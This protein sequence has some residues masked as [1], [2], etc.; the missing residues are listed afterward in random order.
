MIKKVFRKISI[1]ILAL[2]LSLAMN[3]G[4]ICINAAAQADN[5]HKSARYIEPEEWNPTEITAY[6]FGSFNSYENYLMSGGMKYYNQRFASKDRMVRIQVEDPG[7]FVFLGENMADSSVITLYDQTKK[8]ALA[9][10]TQDDDIEYGTRVK[11]KDV[12]YVKMPAKVKEIGLS[13]A[14]IKE[15]FGGMRAGNTYYQAGT[16]K[17]TYHPFSITKRSAVEITISSLE[18]KGGAS[19]AY[20]EKYTKGRW[21]RIGST[22]KLAPG[23]E[24]EDFV[25][26]LQPGKYRLALKSGT[27]QL[28]AASYSRRSTKKKAAY[29]RSKARTIRLNDQIYNVYTP[30]EK[31]SR[32]Y[33]IRIKSTKKRYELSLGK[34]TVSGGYQY[35]IYQ[36]GRKKPIRT[37]KVKS[38]S[39]AKMVK[40]PKKKGTYYIKISKLSKK[41]NGAYEIGYYKH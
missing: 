19:Y 18:R 2:G 41:T 39:N 16:G 37:V 12:F 38:N 25:H 11:A 35:V 5:Q 4:P 22:A 20:L 36:K 15:S 27:R 28:V 17:T 1:G 26:G 30:G 8:K 34:D 7:Y 13:A 14:V 6:Q 31:A 33:K 9:R 40:L 23:M 24:D 29:K 10:S 32:W 3:G 21:T